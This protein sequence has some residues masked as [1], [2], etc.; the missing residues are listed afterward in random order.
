MKKG[1]RASRA[2]RLAFNYHIVIDP[3]RTVL[4][5]DD[6]C[7]MLKTLKERMSEVLAKKLALLGNSWLNDEVF[8]FLYFGSS[9]AS[10][11]LDI[12]PRSFEN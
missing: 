7:S 5:L 12:G 3:N 11:L 9:D 10:L 1:I 8:K 6:L 2:E 4:E